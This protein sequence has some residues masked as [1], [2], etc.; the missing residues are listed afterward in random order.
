MLR[1]RYDLP[2]STASAAARDAYVEGVDRMLSANF[3][4]V[5]PMTAALA[6]D[7]GFALAHAA[8]AR[9]LQFHMRAAEAREAC[10]RAAQLAEQ[11]TPRE[12]RH[13]EIY[14]RLVGGDPRGA[15]AATREHLADFPRD[16][17][18]LAPA[19]GVFGLIGFSGRAGREREQV[20]LLEP[21]AAHY[22]EDWWFMSMLAFA[23]I[24]DG[25]SREGRGLIERS[26][27][28]NPRSAH[29]AHIYVH[30]LYENGGSRPGRDYLEGWLGGYPPD[31]QLHCHLWWHV[32]MF[33]LELGNPARVWEIYASRCS[34]QASRSMPINIVTD[35]AALLWRAELAG[36]ERAPDQWRAVREYSERTFPKPM[37]FVDA[38]YA[39]AL[40]A[41]GDA[42]ALANYAA[43]LDGRDQAGRLVAG[44]VVPALARAAGDF[45]RG[46]WPSAIDRIEPVLEQVVRIGGSRAQRD[47]FEQT[48][49]AA[50]LRAGR[51]EDARKLLARH[52]DFGRGPAVAVRGIIVT[53]PLR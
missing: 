33:E 11:A 27:E 2:L 35:S 13:V 14:S 18:A 9:W 45:M 1:D 47:L 43:E 52:R 20:E 34:P 16:A 37:I 17:M 44:A 6:A 21:L 4:A 41:C 49:L 40:A 24:E 10:A 12:R 30:S 39:L 7:P 3:G 23:L 53:N 29:G 5:S 25:R 28:A 50:Y 51:P 15:L 31:A 42:E 22:G 32:A 36:E 19:T 48:L 38:H 46:D 26:L 8:Q